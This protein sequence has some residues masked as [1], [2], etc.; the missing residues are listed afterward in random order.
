MLIVTKFL[1]NGPRLSQTIS[2]EAHCLAIET[3]D[4]DT[5]YINTICN[6]QFEILCKV[7]R[8]YCLSF[9]LSLILWDQHT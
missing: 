8:A 7:E 6:I 1:I 9:S 2:V 5:F 4:C 3:F